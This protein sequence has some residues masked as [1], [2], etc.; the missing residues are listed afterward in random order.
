M[1]AIRNGNP[2]KALELLDQ[3]PVHDVKWVNDVRAQ[4][5]QALAAK[6]HVQ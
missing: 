5:K 3:Y 4:A 6:K 2:E 1:L